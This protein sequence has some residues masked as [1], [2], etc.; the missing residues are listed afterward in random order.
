[1]WK[2]TINQRNENFK[3]ETQLLWLQAIFKNVIEKTVEKQ[4]FWPKLIGV[5]TDTILGESFGFLTTM[6][7]THTFDPA[8]V[9]LGL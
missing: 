3:I 5:K 6:K 9:F 7:K 1:M 8:S 2:L 4:A